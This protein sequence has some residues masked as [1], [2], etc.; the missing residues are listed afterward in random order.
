MSAFLAGVI[1]AIGLCL[2]GMT[3]PGKVIAFLDVTGD[4]DPSLAFV[5]MG[6]IGVHVF[7]ARRRP[8]VAAKVLPVTPRLLIGSALF[9]IGW[10]LGG[11]CPGPA[12]VSLVALAPVTLAFVAAMVV[13]MLL[14]P[15]ATSRN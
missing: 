9:G 6:A 11:Y 12:L 4:W 15:A 1:F 10:G 14:V 5:M 7:F 3:Q 8:A 13:G 2:S